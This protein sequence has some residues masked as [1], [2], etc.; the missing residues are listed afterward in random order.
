MTG[1]ERLLL[2]L[3]TGTLALGLSCAAQNSGDVLKR[4]EEVF[5]KSCATGY[6]HGVNGG[7]GGAPRLAGRGFDQNYIS[8]VVGRGIPD[9]A[10]ASFAGRLP[11]QDL[12][13]VVAYGAGMNGMINPDAA[14]SGTIA[15]ALTGDAARGSQLFRDAVRGFGRC[16]TCHEVGGFGIPVAGP[17]AKVPSTTAELRSLTTPH[18]KTTVMDGESMPVLVLSS[19][20]QSA[21]F[22]DLTS[23]PPVQRSVEPGGVKFAD[24]TT[25]RHSSVIGAYSDSELAAILSYLRAAINGPR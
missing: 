12:V 19:G 16:S 23:P 22:Y 21:V 9:T 3:V 10:M 4:G 17:M 15:V 1:P 18:V 20:R 6:C 25:W 7:P 14:N 2:R 8:G 5:G 11:R 24:G 13:A